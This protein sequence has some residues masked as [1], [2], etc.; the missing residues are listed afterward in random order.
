MSWVVVGAPAP[1]PPAI[2][3]MRV[4]F[5]PIKIAGYLAGN[6]GEGTPY[7]LLFC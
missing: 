5:E 2:R 1:P 6:Y 4:P 3:H 7:S